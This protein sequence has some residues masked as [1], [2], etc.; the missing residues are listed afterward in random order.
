MSWEIIWND[1][2]KSSYHTLKSKANV[3][4]VN[5][6]CL[7]TCHSR[8]PSPIQCFM[9]GLFHTHYFPHPKITRVHSLF[10]LAAPHFFPGSQY[11]RIRKKKLRV[12]VFR[13]KGICHL[14]STNNKHKKKNH[15]TPKFGTICD[16]SV[17]MV[18]FHHGFHPYGPSQPDH[19]GFSSTSPRSLT[20]R[21]W[22]C[23]KAAEPR[24]GDYAKWN[25]N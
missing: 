21:S 7:P 25:Q 16:D 12:A 14:P 24:E 22:K 20:Q 8:T 2:W 23:K 15:Y 6:C 18:L 11:S 9:C 1:P 13:L 4:Y 3:T 17:W 19:H 10:D 5:L